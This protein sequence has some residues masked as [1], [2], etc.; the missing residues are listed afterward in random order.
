[1]FPPQQ[2]QPRDHQVQDRLRAVAL[3]L[4]WFVIM[5]LGENGYDVRSI[6]PGGCKYLNLLLQSLRGMIWGVEYPLR[7][8]LDP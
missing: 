5:N 7:T 6:L 3:Q 8:C 1:M 2:R 4:H